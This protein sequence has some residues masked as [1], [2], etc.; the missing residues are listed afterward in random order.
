MPEY[1][2]TMRLV[3]G[4]SD[5][6]EPCEVCMQS[7]GDIYLQTQ[8]A[9]YTRASDCSQSWSMRSQAFGHRD[10]VIGLRVVQEVPQ[11]TAQAV[12]ECQAVSA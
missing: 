11:V 1:R 9:G 2:Y 4:G 6:V 7:G 5:R 12:S 3:K 10:C 8:S